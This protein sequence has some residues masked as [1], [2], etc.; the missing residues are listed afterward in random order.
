MKKRAQT[1]IIIVLLIIIVIVLIFI[2]FYISKP[3]PTGFAVGMNQEEENL[4][5]EETPPPI[6]EINIVQEEDPNKEELKKE[7]E[8]IYYDTFS[9]INDDPD[10]K[11]VVLIYNVDSSEVTEP[12]SIIKFYPQEPPRDYSELKAYFKFRGIKAIVMYGTDNVGIGTEIRRATGVSVMVK[13]AEKGE[14]GETVG[15]RD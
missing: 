15:L 1:T 2:G 13:F 6:E 14:R 12:T 11:Q 3:S 10:M 7:T 5:K 4:K 8:L 9:V